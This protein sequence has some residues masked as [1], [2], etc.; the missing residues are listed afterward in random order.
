[1]RNTKVILGALTLMLG[2]AGAISTMATSNVVKNAKI[3]VTTIGGGTKCTLITSP[4]LAGNAA[5]CRTGGLK[6]VF[7]LISGCGHNVF[8]RP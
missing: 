7:T 6:T 3:I 2:L 4:C 8:K 1:M 5:T